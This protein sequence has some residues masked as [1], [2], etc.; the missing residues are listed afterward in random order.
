M[1]GR[2]DYVRSIAIGQDWRRVVSGGW[3]DVIVLHSVNGNVQTR[4]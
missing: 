1:D 4:F 3:C 2:T